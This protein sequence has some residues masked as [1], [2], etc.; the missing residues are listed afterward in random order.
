MD[1]Y[2]S[3]NGKK[4]NF[5]LNY[6]SN[7]KERKRVMITFGVVAI[8]FLIGFLFISYFYEQ[9]LTENMRGY[10]GTFKKMGSI[11]RIGFFVTLLIYPIFLLLKWKPF[12][13]ITLGKFELKTLL[14]FIGRLV[15][16]WHV[17]S[18][19]L[20]TGIVLLHGYMA[21]LKGIK[22]DFTYFSGVITIFVLFLLMFM[23]LKRYK[24][25][26]KNLHFKIAIVFFI[27]FMLHT[28]F[29]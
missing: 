24:K 5:L 11:A 28:I 6:I 21:I 20:S 25:K 19:I 12:R 1:R 2:S 16:Q 3:L 4:H 8:L 26:D 29:A 22:W 15:R 10:K 23:G 27:L 17:P 14:Q 13:K 7:R 9:W 18:A